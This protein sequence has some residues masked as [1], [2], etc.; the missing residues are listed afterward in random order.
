[1][2]LRAPQIPL[3]ESS[4]ATYLGMLTATNLELRMIIEAVFTLPHEKNLRLGI[5]C[6]IELS[7][8]HN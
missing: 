6:M 2:A 5:G 1:M 4:L 7:N 8:L 3:S